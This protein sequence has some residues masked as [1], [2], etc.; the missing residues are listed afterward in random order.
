LAWPSSL[1]TI[2]A[3]TCRKKVQAGCKHGEKEGCR[4]T[5][6]VALDSR[7]AQS[8]PWHVG[9]CTESTSACQKGLSCKLL[10]QHHQRAYNAGECLLKTAEPTASHPHMAAPCKLL[11][12]ASKYCC[13]C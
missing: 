9:R 12:A 3:P 4:L 5:Q 13:C 2:T 6:A 10:T 11:A 8:S 1:V 7:T